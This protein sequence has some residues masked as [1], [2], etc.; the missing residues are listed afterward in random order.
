MKSFDTYGLSSSQKIPKRAVHFY[1]LHFE[2][3]QVWIEMPTL[4]K[5]KKERFNYPNN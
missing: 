5:H 3:S 1:V 2:T 4:W